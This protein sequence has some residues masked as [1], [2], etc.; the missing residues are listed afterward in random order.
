[1]VPTKVCPIVFSDTS[2]SRI[3]V[4]R[5]P[6]AGVQLVKG[7]IE[8]GEQPATAALREL[9]EESGI[10]DAIV[11]R[12]LGIWASG[13]EE[14]IWSF[15]VCSTRQTLPESWIHHTEDDGGLNLAF[16]WHI[17]DEKP[18]DCHPVFQRALRY[19]VDCIQA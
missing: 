14:Q 6:V 1:M 16:Y 5:H 7:T 11:D 15:H 8:A 19:V 13:F 9:C 12:D 17:V 18:Q 3:L 4:F 10:C 2:L